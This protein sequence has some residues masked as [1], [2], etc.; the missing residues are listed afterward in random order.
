MAGFGTPAALQCRE[1]GLMHA[2]NILALLNATRCERCGGVAV[3]G[4]T[5]CLACAVTLT[6]EPMAAKGA[7][8]ERSQ[9]VIQE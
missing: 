6:A 9:H 4:V 8:E 2:E 1:E 3:P 5:M 7:T